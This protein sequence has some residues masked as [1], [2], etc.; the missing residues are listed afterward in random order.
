MT[1]ST[2]FIPIRLMH[3]FIAATLM[4][5]I[6]FNIRRLSVACTNDRHKSKGILGNLRNK[7][8]NNALFLVF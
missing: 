3:A 7:K 5:T 4:S 2:F 8:T 1:L 6:Q